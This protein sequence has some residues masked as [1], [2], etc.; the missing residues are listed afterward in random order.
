MAEI[1]RREA[2]YLWYY[3]SVQ[4]HQ[5]APYWLFGMIVGSLVS[6]FLKGHIHR[7]MG[8]LQRKQW[9]AWGILPASALGILSP[10]CMY[11]TVPI[12]ASFARAGMREDW[13]AAFMMSSILLNPQLFFYSFAL[14]T[15]LALLRLMLCFLGGCAAGALV[16]LCFRDRPFYTFT[17]FNL[18]ESHDT[19]P[20]LLR[21]VLKNLWRNVK[22][23][24]PFFLLGVGLTAL[25]QRYVPANWVTGLFGAN[26]GLGTLMAAALGVPLYTCGGGTIPLLSAWVGEGMS[27]GSAIAFM[28]AGPATKLTNLGAVKI[29]L[30]GRNFFYYVV[31]SI[32]L[33]AL[34][35]L[36][37]NL[38]CG[39][40]R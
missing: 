21:R 22:I 6:V 13:I 9:G 20:N 30:G 12:V 18:P 1:I 2:I 25:Y 32:L 33:A 15:E 8:T 40:I 14:G 37:V 31:F 19:D 36:A 27:W 4:F 5:I 38:F 35:G 3:F 34:L 7:L 16:R 29:V 26:Q 39:G 10:L 23:T 17:A 28:V 24:A 11:G